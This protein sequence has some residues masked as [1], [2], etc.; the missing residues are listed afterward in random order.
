MTVRTRRNKPALG[1][2]PMI[3]PG[4]NMIFRW[5][6]GSWVKYLKWIGGAQLNHTEPNVIT[7]IAIQKPGT[8]L[9][10]IAPARM[11]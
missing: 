4:T 5:A 3:S 10:R 7:R 8:A 9:S 6:M 1:V 11:P 2:S